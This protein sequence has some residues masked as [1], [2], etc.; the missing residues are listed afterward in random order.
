[1]WQ[2]AWQLDAGL[3]AGNSCF[4]PSLHVMF[5][6]TFV[7]FWNYRRSQA[8]D[9]PACCEHGGRG[10]RVPDGTTIPL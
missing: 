6:A 3:H 4:L 10:G 7:H 9:K 2:A 8:C 5:Y 1:M